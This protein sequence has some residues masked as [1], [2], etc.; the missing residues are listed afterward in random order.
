MTTRIIELRNRQRVSGMIAD[1]C[2]EAAAGS[3]YF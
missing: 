1:F 2:R 3:V